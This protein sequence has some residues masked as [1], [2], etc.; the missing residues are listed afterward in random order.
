[1]EIAEKKIKIRDLVQ[2]YEDNEDIDGSIT[3]YGGQLDIRPPYQRSFVYNAKQR[4]EVINTVMKG[5][6]LNIMYWV[7]KKDGNFEIL[8]GQQRTIS[9]CQFYNRD[10]SI[11]DTDGNAKTFN[12]LSPTKKEKFLDYGHTCRKP[13][14]VPIWRTV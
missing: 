6:P 5:F 3:G 11:V 12:N 7:K 14:S 13:P 8:D 2:A 1:M 9:I 10:F 4:A